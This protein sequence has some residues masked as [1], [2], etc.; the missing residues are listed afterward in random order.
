MDGPQRAITWSLDS[1]HLP[2]PYNTP[3]LSP[4]SS[5]LLLPEI[6]L[7]ALHKTRHKLGVRNLYTHTMIANRWMNNWCKFCLHGLRYWEAAIQWLLKISISP[8]KALCVGAGFC[9]IQSHICLTLYISVMLNTSDTYSA[10]HH[11]WQVIV[12]QLHS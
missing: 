11:H 3:T 12:N 6:L 2:P 8:N 1:I 10:Q 4:P 5:L 7:P 9:Q